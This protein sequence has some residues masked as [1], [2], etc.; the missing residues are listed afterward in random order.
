M[1]HIN[2]DRAVVQIEMLIGL[3][4]RSGHVEPLNKMFN[5]TALRCN[6]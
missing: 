5:M 6:D 3:T 4:V 1:V 2:V